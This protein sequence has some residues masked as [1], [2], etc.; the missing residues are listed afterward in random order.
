VTSN[1]LTGQAAT[2]F[3]QNTPTV[4]QHVNPP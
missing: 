2:Y 4:Q 1:H 3:K